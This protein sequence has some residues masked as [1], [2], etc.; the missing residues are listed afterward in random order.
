MYLVVSM[1]AVSW[2][3]VQGGE[4]PQTSVLRLYKRLPSLW[5]R[6]LE[7][8]RLTSRGTQG[9]TIMVLIEYPL[10]SLLQKADLSNCISQS[11]VELANFDIYYKP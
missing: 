10:K 8:L 4:G 6:L 11:A 3:L 1:H 7:S 2:V 5:S 9:H